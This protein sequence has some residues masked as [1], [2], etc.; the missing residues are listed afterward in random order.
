MQKRLYHFLTTAIMNRG[1][2]KGVMYLVKVI[3]LP[4]ICV[5]VKMYF[6]ST[7]HFFTTK[8]SSDPSRS[9][10]EDTEIFNGCEQNR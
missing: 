7:L 2:S 6:P 5:G 3:P 9:H 10:D 8:L 1:I 4:F